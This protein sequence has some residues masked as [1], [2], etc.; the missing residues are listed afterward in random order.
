M[1]AVSATSGPSVVPAA[2]ALVVGNAGPGRFALHAAQSVQVATAARLERRNADGTWVADPVPD[3][4]RGYVLSESCSASPPPACRSLLA[5]ETLRPVAWSGDEC[6]AQCGKPCW[7]ERFQSGVHRLVVTSC[8]APHERFE[9]PMFEMPSSGKALARL[10]AAADV[11]H[12]RA[13]R[14]DGIL[15]LG[16]TASAPGHI[17]GL[18]EISGTSQE[19]SAELTAELLQWLR[20]KDGFNDLVAKRCAPSVRVGFV[21][22]REGPS[23]GGNA[24]RTD[25]SVDL[26]CRA[27][28]MVQNSEELSS[29]YFDPSYQELFSILSRIFPTDR[30][31]KRALE[32]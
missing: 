25:V 27:L 5:G 4:T 21:F 20:S 26:N 14:V 31:L 6:A 23:A 24:Q 29:S 2:P 28:N 17:A 30:E 7:P 32:R 12:V 1:S 9:G 13:A 3:G 18:R 10:R 19:L 16:A 11:A 15:E 22:T 8:T